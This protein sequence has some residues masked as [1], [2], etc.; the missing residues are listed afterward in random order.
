MAT[1]ADTRIHSP[2]QSVDQEVREKVQR[3]L[4]G[5]PYS[6]IFCKVDFDFDQGKLTLR[7]CVP[8]FYLK[9]VLQE[10]LRDIE[11]VKLIKN[12]VDVMCSSGLSSVRP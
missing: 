11:H 5:C 2:K 12:E 7:G 1:I 6:F 4:H 9:Q 3:R 10:L 8:S